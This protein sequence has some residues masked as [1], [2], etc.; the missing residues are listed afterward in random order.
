MT[1]LVAVLCASEAVE[2]QEAWLN[3]LEYLVAFKFTPGLLRLT[4]I[5][6]I[7]ASSS[8]S[9]RFSSTRGWKP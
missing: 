2:G 3:V 8:T 6:N 9:D 4:V 7:G 5:L 1:S